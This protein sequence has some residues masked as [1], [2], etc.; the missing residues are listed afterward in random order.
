MTTEYQ[1]EIPPELENVAGRMIAFK[2]SSL[3]PIKQVRRGPVC[4]SNT[5]QTTIILTNGHS[6]RYPFGDSG[7]EIV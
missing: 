5:H 3:A 6:I 1:E 7:Y 4:W 2:G